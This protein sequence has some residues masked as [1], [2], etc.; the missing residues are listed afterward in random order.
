MATPLHGMLSSTRKCKRFSAKRREQAKVGYLTHKVQAHTMT[1]GTWPG[2]LQFTA[3]R[4]HP[5]P[6]TSQLATT[7]SQASTLSS[8]AIFFGVYDQAPLYPGHLHCIS[9]WNLTVSRRPQQH[10]PIISCKLSS[11]L[12]YSSYSHVLWLLRYFL[13]QLFTPSMGKVM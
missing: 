2:S 5:S 9:A 12:S 1:L 7:T 4:K 10:T 11:K 13:G 8:S 3:E 6:P